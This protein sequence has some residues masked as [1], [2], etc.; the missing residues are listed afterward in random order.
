MAAQ[1]GIVILGQPAFGLSQASI[2]HH[3]LETLH[4]KLWRKF[5]AKT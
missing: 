5:E 1:V 2:R 3:D 4:E